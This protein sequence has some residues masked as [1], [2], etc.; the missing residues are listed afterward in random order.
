MLKPIAINFCKGKK[1][2]AS[3]PQFLLT[4]CITITYETETFAFEKFPFCISLSICV[5]TEIAAQIFLSLKHFLHLKKVRE[6]VERETKSAR[7]SSSAPQRQGRVQSGN[8]HVCIRGNCRKVI[9]LDDK[10]KIE[11]LKRCKKVSE[12]FD[13]RIEAFV[14][15]DNHIHLQITTSCVTEFVRRLLH[16]Y[17]YWYNKKYSLSDK[18]FRTPFKSFCKYSDEWRL[19]SIL[20]I[21]A[22]P[23]NADICSFAEEYEWSSYKLMY[24]QKCCIRNYIDIDTSFIYSHFATRK[25]LDSAIADFIRN[26]KAESALKIASASAG[27]PF[28]SRSRMPIHEILTHLKKILDGKNMY[29]LDKVELEKCIV[30]LKRATGATHYQIAQIF[31]ENY[32]YVRGVLRRNFC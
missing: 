11:F 3:A 16:G 9:F 17:S 23:V 20:Y 22:N 30:N 21:M 27:E 12:Q 1:K 15:M 18:L 10:D 13:T 5:L 7:V 28:T 31:N 32:E 8:L 24:H 4:N 29:T 19:N 26:H 6:M 25:E 2:E 14:I